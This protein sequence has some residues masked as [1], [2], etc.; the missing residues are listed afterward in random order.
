M[1]IATAK[2][3]RKLLIFNNISKVFFKAYDTKVN[4]CAYE[5]TPS[6]VAGG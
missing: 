3:T 1:N 6:E 4:K 5:T 2:L